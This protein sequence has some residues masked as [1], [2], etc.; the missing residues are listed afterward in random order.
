MDYMV[1]CNYLT[2]CSSKGP[3]CRA[4]KN[5]T[6]RNALIDFYQS[7]NDKPIPD[8]CPKLTYVGPPEQTAGYQCPVCGGY[9]NPYHLGKDNRC[10]G[11]GYTLNV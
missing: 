5:N 11:C 1:K 8:K 6:M 9:T 4:C 7:S 10:T 2:R 3:N